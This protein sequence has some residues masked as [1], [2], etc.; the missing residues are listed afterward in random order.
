MPDLFLYNGVFEV[1]VYLPSAW[2]TG[3]FLCVG[4][5]YIKVILGFLPTPTLSQFLRLRGLWFA[6]DPGMLTE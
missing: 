4:V 6:T 1:K 5:H 3:L 2:E